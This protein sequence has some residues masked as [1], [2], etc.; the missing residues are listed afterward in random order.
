MS[1]HESDEE[2]TV[3]DDIVVNKYKMAAEIANSMVQSFISPDCLKL[4]WLNL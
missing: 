1:D 3:L 4:S 2:P